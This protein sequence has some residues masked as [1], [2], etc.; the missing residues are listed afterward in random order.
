MKYTVATRAELAS[1]IHRLNKSEVLVF[2][3]ETTGLEPYLNSQ[4]FSLAVCDGKECVYFNFKDYGDGF[5]NQYILER[6][7]MKPLT[8]KL[9]H[10]VGHNVKF[11]LHFMDRAGIKPF[12]APLD[13]EVWARVFENHHQFK[14]GYSLDQCA[15]RWLGL[16]KDDRVKAYM[17]E[18]GLFHKTYDHETGKEY[19]NYHFDLVPF[20]L[21]SE[22]AMKDAEITWK[23]YEHFQKNM[24]KFSNDVPNLAL[25]VEDKLTPVLFNM[26]KRG[27]LVDKEYCENAF[28]FEKDKAEKL[29]NNISLRLG[30]DFV[31]S[32][33]A[34]A[35]YFES[36]G[37]ELPKTEKGNDQVTEEV[38]TQVGGEVCEKIIAY[39]EAMKRAN[40]YFANYLNR[41]DENNVIHPRF[42]Q[43]GT[44]TGRMSCADPNLQNIPT[45]DDAVYPIRRAFIPREGFI[46][47]SIDY[48]QME[49]RLM[50][51]Y[52]NQEDLIEKIKKGLDPHDA[53]AELTGLERKTAKTLNFGIL[54]RMGLAKLGKALSI[55]E[56][57]AGDFRRSYFAAMPKVKRFIYEAP[58]RQEERGYTYSW[59]GRRFYLDEGTN[60]DGSSKWSYKAANSIIQGGCADVC[61]LAMVEIESYLGT[62]QSRMV[63]Q[64]HDEILLEI[65]LR[66]FHILRTIQKIMEDV[67][68]AKNMPL[69]CSVAYSLESF[70]DMYEVGDDDA[71]STIRK[72]LSSKGAQGPK[73]A[74]GDLVLQSF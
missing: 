35:P 72:A 58:K 18:H 10:W 23:L 24:Y 60:D 11:D 22:Y 68:P 36:L 5:S 6:S 45:T 50:L 21:I 46:F 73:N 51:D 33:K 34:L 7:W 2:D 65:S 59:A 3:T 14:G 15:K 8:T 9:R 44:V 70:H 56:S 54:Y 71:E 57:A 12:G 55:T 4:I 13:T 66:E 41:M 25:A 42:R 31:D 39:R 53:T 47:V 17:D 37:V 62:H 49:F 32:A 19:K 20:E 30:F 64:V 28:A 52:A 63:L 40:T 16:E 48:K 43:S 69:T 61:K 26:E 38:L 74:S 29:A 67:Y 27:V 1:I